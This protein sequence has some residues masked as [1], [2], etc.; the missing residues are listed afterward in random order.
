MLTK[1]VSYSA[2]G[3]IA[4]FDDGLSRQDYYSEKGEVLGKWHGLA[5]EKLGLKGDI[6]REDFAS[7]AKN[8]LPG[9]I[10]EEN[11]HGEK[12]T[13]RDAAGRKVGYDFTFSVSKSVSLAYSLTKDEAILSV[14][15][16]SVNETMQDMEKLMATQARDENGKKY[17]QNTGNMVWGSFVHKRARPTEVKVSDGLMN[18]LKE[19]Y[20]G[21]ALPDWV[22]ERKGTVIASDPN[23][24]V[25][26]YIFNATYNEQK[27]RF[28]AG[29]FD[30]I[31][32]NRQLLEN[33]FHSRVAKGLQD[34]GYTIERNRNNF[35]VVG[36]D[37]SM[38]DKFS[39]RRKEIVKIAEEK[40]ANTA[41][42]RQ[43]AALTSRL[44][45]QKGMDEATIH[46]IWWDRLSDSDKDQVN[47]AKD[48]DRAVEKKKERVTEKEAID[49]AVNHSLE[50]LSVVNRQELL[51]LGVKRGMGSITSLEGLEK[52]LDNRS[53]LLVGQ[54]RRGKTIY[55]KQEAL[56]EEA[57]LKDAA[58]NGRGQFEPINPNY[59]IQ[60]DKLSEEQAKAVN[61]VLQSKDMITIVAG[62][63]GVGKTWSI[64][65]VAKGVEEAGIGF[66][67]F[68]P[69]ASASRGTQ[70]E[71]GFDN[72]DTNA[73]FLLDQMKQENVK[74][75]V[76]WIDE[77]GM[78]GNQTMNH[79][80]DIAKQQNATAICSPE[81][82][83]S[84]IRLNGVMP[85]VSFRILEV[86]N[87]LTLRPFV[88]N[89]PINT[90]KP[91]KLFPMII[92]KRALKYWILLERSS[93]VKASLECWKKLPKNMPMPKKI[94]R[95]H[96]SCSHHS[97]SR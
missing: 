66:H 33:I 46:K 64:K 28:Q 79:I 51:V 35:D 83:N 2:K 14:V 65:E 19:Q 9:S 70:K 34:I 44:G 67:A 22:N 85:F 91:L 29:E 73:S 47:G 92:W 59:Q 43:D 11:P 41:L 82:S 25:H 54:N 55:T 49:Y 6:N 31:F 50:R 36:F 18:E 27:G 5:A 95:I 23:L 3:A 24:H 78:V 16:N 94:R 52:E 17:Y 72:A 38:Q 57:A 84:I 87:P 26:N 12:L 71:E 8:R 69:S 30:A 61:H 68:A 62:G 56:D 60:N 89:K 45:K 86:L 20:K 13:P 75:G 1:S 96:P 37:K 39:N 90:K 63:A 93:K 4:Y 10:T 88:D 81:I 48:G 58:R 15:Q 76:I 74:N 40:G 53:D 77:A 21:E 7:L 80:I 97:R 42:T 32:K